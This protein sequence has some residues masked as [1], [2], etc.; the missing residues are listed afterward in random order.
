MPLVLLPAILFYTGHR[1][2][3]A[4]AKREQL[5]YGAAFVEDVSW[6]GM[7]MPEEPAGR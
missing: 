3:S 2:W 5:D 4:Y 1:H 6:D 7:P